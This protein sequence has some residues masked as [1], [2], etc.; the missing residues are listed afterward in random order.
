MS[1]AS[2]ALRHSDMITGS[3]SGIEGHPPPQYF[4]CK[5]GVGK[6]ETAF[7]RSRVL[8]VDGAKTQPQSDRF[9]WQLT[10]LVGNLVCGRLYQYYRMRRWRKFQKEENF[11][12]DWL[13]CITDDKA[14]TLTNCPTVLLTS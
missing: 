5:S 3:V 13:L 6:G 4:K 7:K 14:K 10:H 9:Y 11:R 2:S 1:K 12:R 8:V